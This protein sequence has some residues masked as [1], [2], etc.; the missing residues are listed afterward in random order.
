[1]DR[2][3]E[4][5]GN[6]RSSWKSVS[7]RH[8]F[9]LRHVHTL[10]PL[11]LCIFGTLNQTALVWPEWFLFLQGFC[12][13]ASHQRQRKEQK[14]YINLWNLQLR[15]IW[16]LPFG[17]SCLE[18][19]LRVLLANLPCWELTWSWACSTK[20]LLFWRH[21]WQMP[22]GCFLSGTTL[23]TAGRMAL[24]HAKKL[25]SLIP[26]HNQ[27]SIFN[28]AHC[29]RSQLRAQQLTGREGISLRQMSACN[30]SLAWGKKYPL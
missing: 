11:L 26:N 19:L 28:C 4:A 18:L 6:P 20:L 15:T 23:I 3:S 2:E 16:F 25:H 30:W 1:M 10:K 21:F 13:N 29:V 9:I 12:C 24:T 27:R 17:L 5:Q 22:V 7:K 8:G 14:W